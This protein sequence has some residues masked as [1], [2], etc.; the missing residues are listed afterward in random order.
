[1]LVE[2]NC[3]AK[4]VYLR[5]SSSIVAAPRAQNGRPTAPDIFSASG[6]LPCIGQ[7]LHVLPASSCAKFAEELQRVVRQ[8]VIQLFIDD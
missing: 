4:Q 6:A 5:Y 2:Q 8:G 1:M 7:I 3:S